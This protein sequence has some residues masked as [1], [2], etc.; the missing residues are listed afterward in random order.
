MDLIFSFFTSRAGLVLM[1]LA[2][3]F[4]WHVR[5]KRQAIKAYAEAARIERHS[6]VAR[7][8][9]DLSERN[10]TLMADLARERGKV[11]AAAPQLI[12][13][14]TNYVSPLADSRCIV[15][16]G[17]VQHHDAA[18]GMSALPAAA[19]ELVDQ[20]SGI[21]LS[22]VESVATENASI[23]HE[24]KLE[25]LGWRK[26]YRLNTDAYNAWCRKNNACKTTGETAGVAP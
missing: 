18:W 9:V 14:V 1:A 3:A 2:L 15:P 24:W 19:P 13:E 20:P 26:W 5:D 12:R 17:F 10:S 22:R 8:V 4:G 7:Y 6:E 11:Q 16:A 25:S 23:C 21:S